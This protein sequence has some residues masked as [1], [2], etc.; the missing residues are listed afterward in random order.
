MTSN[1]TLNM[2][3]RHPLF[4]PGRTKNQNGLRTPGAGRSK[5]FG[6]GSSDS[7]VL[8]QH[9]K[10]STALYSGMHVRQ[11]S[12][13][14]HVVDSFLGSS[15]SALRNGCHDLI[16]LGP[17]GDDCFL[18]A[19]GFGPSLLSSAVLYSGLPNA[20]RDGLL[21]LTSPSRQDELDSC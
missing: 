17:Q 9:P 21:Y 15:I 20:L 8:E 16:I 18:V 13:L 11:Q 3:S 7:Y 2:N 5:N 4:G 19:W 1:R 14:P 6:S 10:A 12:R